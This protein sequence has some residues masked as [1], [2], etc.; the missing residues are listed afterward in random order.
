M[1]GSHV[2]EGDNPLLGATLAPALP[3]VGKEQDAMVAV[4][5]D[6]GG[7]F[8]DLVLLNPATGQVYLAKVPSMPQAL[9]CAKMTHYRRGD[10]Y[11]PGRR[12]VCLL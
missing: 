3:K 1:A 8:T 7:A 12:F 5:V 11:F 4:G 6:A 9:L 2:L 10:I